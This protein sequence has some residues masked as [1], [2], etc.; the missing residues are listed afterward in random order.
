MPQNAR[1]IRSNGDA[2]ERRLEAPVRSR[3]WPNTS[4]GSD[5]HP[6]A[7]T[8]AC[9]RYLLAIGTE[10]LQGERGPAP[11]LRSAASG[12]PC[13]KAGVRAQVAVPLGT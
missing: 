3:T 13:P 7:V 5:L 2:P 9:V 11:K 8:L 4:P 12:T 10:R 1:L 6:V